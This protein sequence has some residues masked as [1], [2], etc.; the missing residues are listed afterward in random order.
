MCCV[1]GDRVSRTSAINDHLQVISQSKHDRIVHAPPTPSHADAL[2]ETSP[3]QCAFELC[4]EDDDEHQN[5]TCE[6]KGE[7]GYLRRPRR[8]LQHLRRLATKP[9]AFPSSGRRHERISAGGVRHYHGYRDRKTVEWEVIVG[10]CAAEERA[11]SFRVWNWA[12]G[13]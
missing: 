4:A 2:Q 7:I 13:C 1:E 6:A 5:A 8:R 10:A 9:V 11:W 12:L 3:R